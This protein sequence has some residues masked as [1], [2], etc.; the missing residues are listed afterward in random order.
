MKDIQH[1]G[2]KE[3]EQNDKRRS[4]KHNH[5]TKDRVSKTH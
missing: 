1:N 5:T 3:K 4:A 2:P